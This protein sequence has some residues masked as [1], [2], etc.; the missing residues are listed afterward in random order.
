MVRAVDSALVLKLRDVSYSRCL[1][2][3]VVTPS[4]DGM[5]IM[6]AD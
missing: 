5:L 4:R 1:R 6:N 3:A 2:Q